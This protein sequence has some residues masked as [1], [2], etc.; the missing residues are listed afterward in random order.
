MRKVIPVIALSIAVAAG[1]AGG[2]VAAAPPPDKLTPATFE[3]IKSR[4]ALTQ[5]ELVWQRIPWRDGFFQALLEAQAADKPI[6][7]WLYGGDPRGNC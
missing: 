2:L 1:I 4:V 6:F 5:Q 3:A 7:Y